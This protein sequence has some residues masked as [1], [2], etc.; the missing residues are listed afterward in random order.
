MTV[1]NYVRGL[2]RNP[3]LKGFNDAQ[4][5]AQFV[6]KRDQDAFAELVRKHGPSVLGICRRWSTGGI[7]PQ[8]AFQA[9]FLILATKAGVVSWKPD[10]GPWLSNVAVKVAMEARQKEITRKNH[11]KEAGKMSAK[12]DSAPKNILSPEKQMS[13]LH[14]E[15]AR[16]PERDQKL[17]NLKY[18]K[19]VND[20]ETA[21]Q[22]GISVRALYTHL[23]RVRNSLKKRLT[24]RG[25][26]LSIVLLTTAIAQQNASAVSAILV[27]STSRAAVDFAYDSNNSSLSTAATA[28]AETFLKTSGAAKK[29]LGLALFLATGIATCGIGYALR[30]KPVVTVPSPIIPPMP[31]KPMPVEDLATSRRRQ[32]TAILPTILREI[33]HIVPG[34]QAR[35]ISAD[36]AADTATI[37]V[38]WQVIFVPIYDLKLKYVIAQEELSLYYRK[39]NKNEWIAKDPARPVYATLGK[40]GPMWLERGR[41]EFQRIGKAL[42]T[43]ADTK[44]P[45]EHK[46]DLSAHKE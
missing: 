14:E 11:E 42:E 43:L 30:E 8:D 12:D 18:F 31:P 9:V 25:V 32:L 1:I 7:D 24:R 13:I 22:L 35:L 10:I 40:N 39:S 29:W 46:A 45:R 5:L 19:T 15:I 26:E 33:E 3:G 2:V 36:V 4:L 44:Q 6:Q 16:L 23:N 27:G 28:L 41:A 20:K 17:I 37:A 21:E 38:K 34:S